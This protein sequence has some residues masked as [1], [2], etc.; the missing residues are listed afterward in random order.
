MKGCIIGNSHLAAAKLGWAKVSADFPD[1]ELDFFGSHRDSMFRTAVRDG[2]LVALDAGVRS[3]LEMTGG[4]PDIELG[5]YDFFAVVGMGFG[6]HP[7]LAVFN[8]HAI[9]GYRGKDHHLISDSAFAD[10]TRDLLRG[11]TA[12]HVWR[13]L[14]SSGDQPIYILPQPLSADGILR[15]H[16]RGA[17]YKLIHRSGISRRIAALFS[18]VSVTVFDDRTVVIHQ[19]PATVTAHIFTKSTFSEG[20]MRLNKTLDQAHSEDDHFH[21]NGAYGAVMLRE[22]LIRATSSSLPPADGTSAAARPSLEKP[23]PV[24]PL[25]GDR[26]NEERKARRKRKLQAGE[27]RSAGEKKPRSLWRRIRRRFLRRRP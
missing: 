22:M 27:K 2:R 21:M 10:T 13:L 16:N 4:S 1:V 15:T 17:I 14:R 3:K 6:L 7:V 25:S 18:E 11:S 24:V 5:R 23:H 19:P 20:S 8:T 12:G 9:A 26:E